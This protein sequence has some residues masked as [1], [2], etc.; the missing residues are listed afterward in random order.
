MRSI[1]QELVICK[2][3]LIFLQ[4]APSSVDTLCLRLVR[5]VVELDPFDIK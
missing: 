1:E 5:I 3:K 4:I 2:S